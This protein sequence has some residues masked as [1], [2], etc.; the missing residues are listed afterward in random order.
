[1][2]NFLLS[3]F[4]VKNEKILRFYLILKIQNYHKFTSKSFSDLSSG[5][6]RSV[7][8][9]LVPRVT[10][11]SAPTFLAF[12]SSVRFASSVFARFRTH[13]S[14]QSSDF[15]MVAVPAFRAFTDIVAFA[16]SS[17]ETWNDAFGCDK[18]RNDVLICRGLFKTF[19]YTIDTAIHNIP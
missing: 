17:V 8:S 2:K 16:F 10:E 1:M 4:K 11:F 13:R 6:F 12:A 9:T 5:Q 18:I 3:K 15:A 14:N 19:S 7:S